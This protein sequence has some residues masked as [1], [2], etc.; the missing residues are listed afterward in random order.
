MYVRI[1]RDLAIQKYM[2]VDFV[3]HFDNCH[4]SAVC[5]QLHSEKQLKCNN[6]MFN[7]NFSYICSQNENRV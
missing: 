2:H 5:L 4:S 1:L 6:V 7:K 3:P